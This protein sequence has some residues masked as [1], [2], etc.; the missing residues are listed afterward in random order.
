VNGRWSPEDDER[1]RNELRW[2]SC[3][4]RAATGFLRAI[5]EAV[6]QIPMDADVEGLIG[7]DRHE[8]TGDRFNAWQQFGM[9]LEEPGRK[10]GA[11]PTRPLGRDAAC[12]RDMQFKSTEG[13]KRQAKADIHLRI[14]G[15]AGIWKW[16]VT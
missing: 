15:C 14:P 11:N 10:L 6:R 1:R 13:V 5:V 9:E 3:C 8:S 16:T 7:A 4:R 2:L 12:A